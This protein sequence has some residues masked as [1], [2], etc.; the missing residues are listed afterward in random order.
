MLA[1]RSSSGSSSNNDP[2]HGAPLVSIIT[3]VDKLIDFIKI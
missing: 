1:T 3:L 2:D